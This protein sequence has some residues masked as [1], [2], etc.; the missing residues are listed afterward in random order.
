MLVMVAL[1]P[2]ALCCFCVFD[3]RDAHKVVTAFTLV[4]A[5]IALFR[6]PTVAS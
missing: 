3:A 4:V 6:K 5:L 2:A 1:I